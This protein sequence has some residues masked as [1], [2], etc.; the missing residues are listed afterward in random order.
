[1]S[2][3]GPSAE[4]LQVLENLPSHEPRSR[5]EPFRALILR[6]SEAEAIAVFRRFKWSS[7]SLR[8]R[9]KLSGGLCNDGSG[10][11]LLSRQMKP[12]PVRPRGMSPSFQTDVSFLAGT[13]A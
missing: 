7:A 4:L 3:H 11:A 6:W 2:N 9:M 12:V 8:L 5:L 10:R 13:Q 1:M